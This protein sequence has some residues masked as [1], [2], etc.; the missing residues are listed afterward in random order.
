MASPRFAAAFALC[1]ALLAVTHVSLTSAFFLPIFPTLPGVAPACGVG[2]T[3][4]TA[5]ELVLCVAQKARIPLG[6]YAH[7][8][9]HTPPSRATNPDI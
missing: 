2:E 3:S 5:A 6:R 8:H 1:A 7:T 4:F 9:T